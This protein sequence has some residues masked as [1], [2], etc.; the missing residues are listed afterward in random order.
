MNALR[1][2]T[3]TKSFIQHQQNQENDLLDYNM[4][5]VMSSIIEYRDELEHLDTL[6][7]SFQT[8]HPKDSEIETEEKEDNRKDRFLESVLIVDK[9]LK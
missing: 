1:L 2:E 7:T 4:L 5:N 8:Y 3:L 9:E 6:I